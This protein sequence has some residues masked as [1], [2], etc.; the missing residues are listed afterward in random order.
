MDTV[1]LVMMPIQ[2]GCESPVASP[3]S[4]H[5]TEEAAERACERTRKQFPRRPADEPYAEEVPIEVLD[6]PEATATFQV[7]VGA[8][9]NWWHDV[10]ALLHDAASSC[11]VECTVRVKR[12]TRL[13]VCY[14][15][16]Y[17]GLRKD[18]RRAAN[19]VSTWVNQ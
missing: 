11:G 14:E 16:A 3:M 7:E 17:R 2:C 8:L 19:R 4:A 5:L 9:V 18:V 12:R 15:V 10:E 13:E 6:E 1:W